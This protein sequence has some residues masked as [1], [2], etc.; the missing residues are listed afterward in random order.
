MTTS[1]AYFCI[2]Y[3]LHK[4][5]SDLYTTECIPIY[6]VCYISHFCPLCL[7]LETSEI[8]ALFSRVTRPTKGFVSSGFSC[9]RNLVSETQASADLE[10]QSSRKMKQLTV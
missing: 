4:V 5:R 10:K 3:W 2:T 7:I 1:I 8:K 9:S 6:A